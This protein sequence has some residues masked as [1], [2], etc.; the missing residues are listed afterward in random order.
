MTTNQNPNYITE[1]ERAAF[2]E[3]FLGVVA[4]QARASVAPYVNQLQ[5]QNEEL[6]NQV[7]RGQRNQ[8]KDA[9]DRAVPNWR[10]INV[11]PKF[12]KWLEQ[13]HGMAGTS[14]NNLL[15]ASWS[16][17]R[18]DQVIA[19][20]NGFLEAGGGQQQQRPTHDVYGRRMTPQ[21]PPPT[22]AAAADLCAQHGY[23]RDAAGRQKF[24]TDISRGRFRGTLQEQ[25]QIS[26]ELIR[27]SMGQLKSQGWS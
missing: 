18:Q 9:L 8:M 14:I 24:I 23:S 26:N 17:N 22:S 16:T 4:K 27:A 15:Q 21:A 6:R 20:F 11:D 19:I 3:D 5:Q 7:A 13:H 1:D 10:A 12:I 25:E 2:G